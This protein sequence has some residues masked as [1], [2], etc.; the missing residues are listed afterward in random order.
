MSWDSRDNPAPFLWTKY[1]MTI[2]GR[3][4]TGKWVYL[5]ASFQLRDRDWFKTASVIQRYAVETV[6]GESFPTC[7]PGGRFRMA[8]EIER[9]KNWPKATLCDRVHQMKMLRCCRAD[10]LDRTWMGSYI[11]DENNC[12]IVHPV[13]VII[14]IWSHRCIRYCESCKRDNYI[15]IE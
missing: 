1:V 13:T 2:L 7:Q 9:Q 5:S 4:S 11:S 15:H 8:L 3:T 6:V 12:Q 10:F 14:S